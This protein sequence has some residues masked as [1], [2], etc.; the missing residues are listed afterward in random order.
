MPKQGEPLK[1][2]IAIARDLESLIDEVNRFM[3]IDGGRWIP[4]AGPG[5]VQTP[6]GM[7]WMQAMV[8]NPQW[9]P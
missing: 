2:T 4:Q 6:D 7:V 3:A 9:R 1:Y 5:A 8:L